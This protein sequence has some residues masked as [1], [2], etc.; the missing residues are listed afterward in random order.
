MEGV[1]HYHGLLMVNFHNTYLNRETFPDILELYRGVI[2]RASER[3]YWLA[4]AGSCSKWWRSREASGP[5]TLA[6][7]GGRFPDGDLQLEEVSE[8]EVGEPWV[9]NIA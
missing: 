3:G 4:T 1:E 2:E 7:N 9:P 5:A 6:E 8:K